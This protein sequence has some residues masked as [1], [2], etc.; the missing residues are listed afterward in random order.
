MVSEKEAP[1]SLSTDDRHRKLV[2]LTAK[3]LQK[4]P[5]QLADIK[6]AL[7]DQNY[8]LVKRHAH[9]IKGTSG[10]YRLDSICENAVRLE[11]LADEQIKEESLDIISEM[12]RLIKEQIRKLD[13]EII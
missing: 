1:E 6:T 8:A 13:L 9:N 2:Q 3:Y 5:Q 11:Y 12:M 4:L 7:E 10:T